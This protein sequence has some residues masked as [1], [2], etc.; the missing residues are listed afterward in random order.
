MNKMSEEEKKPPRCFLCSKNYADSLDELHYCICDIAICHE[1][2]N[3]VKK[4]D[5]IWICPKCKA[6]NNIQESRLFREK[7]I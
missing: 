7:N 5:K 3:S 4:N 1:C 6:E 2:I